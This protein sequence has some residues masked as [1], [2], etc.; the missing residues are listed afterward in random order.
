MLFLEKLISSAIFKDIVIDM[1]LQV[2][3][4]LL[5]DHIVRI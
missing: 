1:P 4:R 2:M 5:I 3:A